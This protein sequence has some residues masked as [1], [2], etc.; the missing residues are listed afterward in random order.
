MRQKRGILSKTYLTA[1]LVIMYIPILLVIIYS[2]NQSRISSVW[3][4][5]SWHWYTELFRDRAMWSALWNSVFLGVTASLAAAVIGSLAATGLSRAKLPGGKAMG[6]MAIL[7]IMIPEIVMG[8]V[9]LAFFAILSLPFGMLTLVIAHTAMCIPY[10]FLMV[11]ARLEGLDK[12]Y[13]EAAKDL[14]AGE[15]RAF[16]DITRPLIMPAVASS[17]LISFAMSFDD[18][19]VSVFV[20]G[21]NTNTLPIRIY[22]QMKVGVTPKTNAMCTL[23]FAATIVL[24]MISA[25]ISRPQN[26]KAKS[27]KKLANSITNT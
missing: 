24:V 6:Y 14:G 8:M 7:P 16:Y 21:V 9:S 27:N 3:S 18:V 22:T 19:I 12:S 23:L 13:V 11:K 1:V 4:G 15:W 20:T 25:V 2:F 10:S 17:I 26:V 5:F